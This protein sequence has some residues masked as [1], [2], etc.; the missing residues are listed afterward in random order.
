MK[1]L[2]IIL[3]LWMSVPTQAQG[4]TVWLHQKKARTDYLARQ[5]AAWNT[6]RQVLRQGYALGSQGLTLLDQLHREIFQLHAGHLSSWQQPGQWLPASGLDAQMEVLTTQMR[7]I[8]DQVIR[9]AAQSG[10]LPQQGRFIR[11]RLTDLWSRAQQIQSAYRT[12]ESTDL[13]MRQARRWMDLQ[14][15]YLQMCDLR[16]AGLRLAAMLWL[17]HHRALPPHGL[18]QFF[19]TT[20]TFTP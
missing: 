18:R 13:G 1:Y 15:L 8:H 4:L 2:P 10:L 16:T 9:L 5:L 19:S 11:A 12:L 20:Q 7:D 6:Y 17:R 14:R 3:W